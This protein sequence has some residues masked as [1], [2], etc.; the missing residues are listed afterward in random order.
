M[1][2]MHSRRLEG[3]NLLTTCGREK[4]ESR[5]GGEKEGERKRVWGGFRTR[6]EGETGTITRFGFASTGVSVDASSTRTETKGRNFWWAL[7]DTQGGIGLKERILFKVRV[8]SVDGE[9]QNF[10]RS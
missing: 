3:N 5:E 7:G 9:R 2:D 4:T 8:R 6:V 1:G 10:D